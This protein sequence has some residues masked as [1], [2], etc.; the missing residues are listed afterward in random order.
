VTA[1]SEVVNGDQAIKLLNLEQG[2]SV[3]EHITVHDIIPL[4]Q[5]VKEVEQ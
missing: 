1:T 5:A 4:K 2:I 3:S